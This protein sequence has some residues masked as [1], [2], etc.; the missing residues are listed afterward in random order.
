VVT[1]S[2]SAFLYPQMEN[3]RKS[4]F[5]GSAAEGLDGSGVRVAVLDTGVDTEHPDL[6]HAIS[7][8]SRSYV[9]G[10]GDI[11]D[12][13]GHGTHIS[14]IIA[15]NGA[16]S[17][18]EYRGI[19]PGVELIVLKVATGYSGFGHDVAAGVQRAVELGVDIINYSGGTQGYSIGEPPWKWPTKLNVRDKAF[20]IA[21]EK[22]ILCVA[23]AGNEGPRQG[24]TVRPGNLE[25]VLCVGALTLPEMEVA[26][27]SARGPDR[28]P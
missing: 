18:G 7:S 4:L 23:A 2:A 13:H 10:T 6:R 22:G 11:F 12:Y 25:N 15:G 24:T 20:A 28:S 16:A 17:G 26:N 8:D 21:A 5:L 27:S 3:T 1:S 9:A 19:A 14:G